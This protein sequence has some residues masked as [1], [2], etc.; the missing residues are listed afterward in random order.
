MKMDSEKI[1]EVVLALLRLTSFEKL[2]A[3]PDE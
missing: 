1:D 2:F 3:K